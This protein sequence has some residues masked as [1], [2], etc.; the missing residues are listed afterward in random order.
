ML[1]HSYNIIYRSNEVQVTIK[2]I[3]LNMQVCYPN[4][5]FK[6]NISQFLTSKLYQLNFLPRWEHLKIITFYRSIY[7]KLSLLSFTIS[8]PHVEIK[9]HG[10]SLAP[11]LSVTLPNISILLYFQ[12]FHM[13]SI[14]KV[15]TER[16][17]LALLSLEELLL[18]P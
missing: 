12:I 14:N 10:W 8:A 18:S 13:C 11:R 2:T 17:K 5:W 1:P 3:K 15:K 16:L 6:D 4:N 9:E 7:L